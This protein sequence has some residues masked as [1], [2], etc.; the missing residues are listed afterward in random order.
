[1]NWLRWLFCPHDWSKEIKI[2]DI[3]Y[4]SSIQKKQLF[5]R[6]DILYQCSKCTRFKKVRI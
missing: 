5:E 1:M 6:E 2:A 4:W 3:Y